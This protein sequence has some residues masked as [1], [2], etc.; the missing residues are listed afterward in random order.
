MG[1]IA[2]VFAGQG[3]QYPGMARG[4][5]P[6]ILER[7]DTVRPGTTK[8]MMEA[9]A[10]ELMKTDVTQPCVYAAD[11]AA[12][13]ALEKRG[14]KADA[15]A[16]YSVDPESHIHTLLSGITLSPSRRSPSWLPRS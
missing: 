10:E 8:Q 2:F 14:I 15:V 9:D 7:L 3:A 12:A 4:L 11:L 13:F 5:A 6:D 16:G 1:K